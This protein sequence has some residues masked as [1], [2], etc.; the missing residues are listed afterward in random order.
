MLAA[1]KEAAAKDGKGEYDC[2]VDEHQACSVDVADATHAREPCLSAQAESLHGAP[3]TMGEVEPNGAEPDEVEDGVDDAGDAGVMERVLH[4]AVAVRGG[5]LVGKSDAAV[6]KLR[7]HHVEPEV[8]EVEAKTKGNDDAKD[9][10]VLAGPFY[11]LGL[12]RDGIAVLAASLAIL[13]RQDDGIN[14]MDGYE[15]RK[16]HCAGHCIPITAQE[17]ANHVVAFG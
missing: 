5:E 2:G 8:V 10:H 6:C 14:E 12:V 3:H 1:D 13:K 7:K 16:E 15:C 9:E 17:L 11:L 4:H